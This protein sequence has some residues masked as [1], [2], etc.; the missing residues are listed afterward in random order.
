V[1]SVGMDSHVGDAKE[2][3][4]RGRLLGLALDLF[5]GDPAGGGR[6]ARLRPTPPPARARVQQQQWLQ[7]VKRRAT[8]LGSI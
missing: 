8:A 3:P 5:W 2:D 4:P 6:A 1:G 7:G